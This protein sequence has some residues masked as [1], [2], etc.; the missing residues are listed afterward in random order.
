[1]SSATR[2]AVGKLR[3]EVS[4]DRRDGTAHIGLRFHKRGRPVWFSPREW[5]DLMA[6]L[7]SVDVAEMIHT[8]YDRAGPG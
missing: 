4:V 1:M 8:A 7:N 3:L 5:H 6:D 2:A